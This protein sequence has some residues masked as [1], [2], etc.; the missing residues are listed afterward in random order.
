MKRDSFIDDLLSKS[1]DK[2]HNKCLEKK[3]ESEVIDKEDS[4]NED[5]EEN[6]EPFME[7][8]EI[9]GAGGVVNV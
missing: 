6:E 4:E 9:G 7:L 5:E 1:E 3:K 8:A 2:K